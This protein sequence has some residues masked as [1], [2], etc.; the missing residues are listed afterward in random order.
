MDENNKTLGSNEVD[1]LP[2]SYD[3]LVPTN[4]SLAGYNIKGQILTIKVRHNVKSVTEN[5]TVTRNIVIVDPT[6]HRQTGQQQVT[7]GRAGIKDLV[8]GQTNWKAWDPAN[9]F[10]DEISTPDFPGYI[11]HG[12]IDKVAV[13]PNSQDST[14]T[15]TYTK[16]DSGSHS[17]SQTS[18]A[19]SS[20]ASSTQ[21]SGSIASSASSSTSSSAG[22]SSSSQTS[23]GSVVSPTV[24]FVVD[25]IDVDENNKTLSSNEVDHLP[26]RDRKS[27]V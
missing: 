21:S 26:S 22:S 25:V 6:G 19:G 7:F 1:H 10:F 8:T 4:Y 12:S 5:K 24:K 20:T 18:S 9:A 2:S 11:K 13:T 3:S 17:G 16:N 15:I 27:V 23:S 14:V